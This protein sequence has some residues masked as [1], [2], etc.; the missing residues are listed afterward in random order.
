[1]RAGGARGTGATMNRCAPNLHPSRYGRQRRAVLILNQRR[2]KHVAAA[3]SG[4][5]RRTQAIQEGQRAVELLP[6]SKDASYASIAQLQLAE[7]YTVVGEP[8]VAVDQLGATL[9]VPSPVSAAGLK[10]DPTW[11]PL[12][13][14]PRFEQ[15]VAGK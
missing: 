8:G 12:R 9:G 6:L 13:G 7:I 2:L 4:L 5:G 11:A 15:L 1:M 3:Q 10:A 14:N